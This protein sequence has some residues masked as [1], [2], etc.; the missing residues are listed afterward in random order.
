MLDPITITVVILLGVSFGM[1]GAMIS[2][3]RKTALLLNEKL[4]KPRREILL[5]H[6]PRYAAIPA[7]LRDDFEGIV[8]VLMHRKRF[9]P[10]GGLEEI[11]DKQKVLICA[12]AALPIV[13]LP[14]HKFYPRLKSI[15]V[16][17]GAFRDRGRRRWGISEEESTHSNLG[18]SWQTGSVILS[19]D[20]VVAGAANDDDGMNVVIHEF[21]HQLDQVDGAADG[22]PILKNRAAYK[23]WVEVF[24]RNYEKLVEEVEA[25]KGERSFL[26]PYGATNPAEFFAV[27]AETFF[28]EALDLKIKHPD[29]YAE[30]S[31][32]F[33]LDPAS[34]DE[35]YSSKLTDSEW[36]PKSSS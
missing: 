32:Y 14:N 10:C 3:N 30:L 35:T 33:H 24:Y 22:I 16:Y 34:W 12:Q 8:N 13:A 20:S 18:E 1:I 15:L 27:A 7:S 5:K 11:T 4:S 9:V 28:E 36:N 25:G 23:R 6:F 29:L 2:R 21:A 31:S 17:P 19:W 26:D